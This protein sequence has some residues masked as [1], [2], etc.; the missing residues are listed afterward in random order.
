MAT[1]SFKRRIAS[2]QA[3]SRKVEGIEPRNFPSRKDD[4]VQ[5]MEVNT[6]STVNGKLLAASRGR[7]PW[8]V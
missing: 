1:W 4:I 6:I 7:R 3:V 8:H 5:Q 2:R